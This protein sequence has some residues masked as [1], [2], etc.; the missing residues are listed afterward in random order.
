MS[1]YIIQ[2]AVYTSLLDAVNMLKALKFNVTMRLLNSQVV[3]C[4]A[5]KVIYMGITMGSNPRDIFFH[6]SRQITRIEQS[7]RL[8]LG[9]DQTS[10]TYF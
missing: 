2:W 1:R 7:K 10:K 8:K 6:L 5:L 9:T 4:S 3:E